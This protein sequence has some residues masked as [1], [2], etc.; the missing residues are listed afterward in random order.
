[1]AD[2]AVI[3]TGGKQYKVREGESLLVERLKEKKGEEIEFKDLLSQKIV[4][5]RIEGEEKGKK[6][7][8]FKYK[9]RKRERRKKGHR[10]IYTKISI[11]KIG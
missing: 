7:I 3:Q 1:M 11:S 5:A 8:V 10:Q 4:K 9:P 6:L 2:F